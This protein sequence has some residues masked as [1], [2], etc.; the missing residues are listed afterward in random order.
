M[1]IK[2]DGSCSKYK[3]GRLSPFVGAISWM[4]HEVITLNIVFRT[5]ETYNKVFE[6]KCVF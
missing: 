5:I 4:V 2:Y 1:I 6:W 3:I